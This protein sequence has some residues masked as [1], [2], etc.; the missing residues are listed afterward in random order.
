MGQVYTAK[1]NN[2]NRM[3]MQKKFL[4]FFEYSPDRY[5]D[6]FKTSPSPLLMKNLKKQIR[7]LQ[8]TR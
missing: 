8:A 7:T 6:G 3:V 5:F 2:H 4:L 1:L